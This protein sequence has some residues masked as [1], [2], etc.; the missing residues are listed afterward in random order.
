MPN[1]RN[2]DSA[3][4][5]KMPEASQPYETNGQWNGATK[6]S[7]VIHR[8]WPHSFIATCIISVTLAAIRKKNDHGNPFTAPYT[9]GNR[10][11]PYRYV[12]M[13]IVMPSGNAQ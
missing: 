13:V 1:S 6:I 12:P 9:F 7:S 8:L 4:R 5:A 10:V 11:R 2:A 3:H